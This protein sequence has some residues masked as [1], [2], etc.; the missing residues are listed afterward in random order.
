MADLFDMELRAWR[1]DRAFRNGPELFLY[2]RA[3]ADC[4]DRLGIVQ[5]FFRTA[6]LIGCPDAG[7]PERLR[8]FA[9]TVDI[10][11]PGEGFT[12][13]FPLRQTAAALS[14]CG[15]ADDQL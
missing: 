12:R 7:W 3:F 14:R 2:E 1:R 6:L 10:F 4:L 11:D 13:S 8:E 9:E 5:R 15:R